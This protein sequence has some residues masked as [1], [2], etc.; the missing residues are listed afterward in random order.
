MANEELKEQID[1]KKELLNLT[2]K[3]IDVDDDSRGILLDQA[4]LLTGAVQSEKDNNKLINYFI[5]LG[6]RDSFYRNIF[7]R[8]GTS[9][10]K[11]TG[12]T[13]LLEVLLLFLEI[14]GK[15]FGRNLRIY[16]KPPAYTNLLNSF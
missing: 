10:C 8:I 6:N 1:L 13:S 12:S 9:Q 14:F 2:Q 16:H 15:V 3:I 7:R 11:R 5:Y 4:S